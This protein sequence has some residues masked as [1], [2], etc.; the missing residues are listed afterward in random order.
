MMKT[1][2]EL[3]NEKL[4]RLKKAMNLEKA[5]R[6]PISLEGACFIKFGE[7]SAVLADFIRRPDWADDMCLKGYQLMPE[8][9]VGP[10]SMATVRN[11]GAVWYGGTKLPGRE[12]PEDALW[13]IDEKG[14]MTEVDYDFIIEK[15]WQ[16]MSN[17]LQFN[18]LGY[19]PE[20]I[21]PDFAYMG[22]F[23]KKVN[24]AGF[25][26]TNGGVAMPPFEFLSGARSVSK[27]YMDLRRMPD[28]VIAAMDVMMEEMAAGLKM[29][30]AAKPMTMF[31]AGTRAAGEFMSLKMFEKFDWPHR[32]ALADVIIE[33]GSKPYFHHDSNWENN[34]PYFA[35]FPKASCVFDPDSATDIF[36]IKEILGDRMCI[37]GDV[38]AA[39]TSIGTPDDCY[40]YARKLMDGIGPI[41]FIMSSGCHLP[42]N[43]KLE[44]VKA[45]VAAATG[46]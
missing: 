17:E 16:A 27:F 23:H 42:P 40:N 39:L 15:G 14:P 26:I 25:A 29:Q 6:I 2:Q 4:D 24:D 45:I 36:K 5:D 28:K 32:K 11:I 19:K 35:E 8:L 41:G 33:A 31:F 12:V 44:N 13:Q 30:L 21:M 43:A 7:P 9:D 10:S 37:T 20:D 22:G 38:P 34:L 18:R 3:Y 1:N 46:K